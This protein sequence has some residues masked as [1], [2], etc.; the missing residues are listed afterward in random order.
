MDRQPQVEGDRPG[1]FPPAEMGGNEKSRAAVVAQLGH[2]FGADDL[3][4]FGGDARQMGKLAHHPSD[5]VPNLFEDGVDLCLGL[6]R[7]GAAEIAPGL[8]VDREE[9]PGGARHPTAEGRGLIQGKG[10]KQSPTEVNP[11]SLR[12]IA[13]LPEAG[14]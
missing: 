11:A 2:M 9:P 10:G 12:A 13:H 8:A 14:E 4:A 3:Q 7:E 1:Q 6:V 5:I